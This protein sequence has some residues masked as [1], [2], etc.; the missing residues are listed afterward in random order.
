MVTALRNAAAPALRGWID[1]H[2]IEILYATAPANVGFMDPKLVDV[3]D[4]LRKRV[5]AEP[6]T[7]ALKQIGEMLGVTVTPHTQRLSVAHS[8]RETFTLGLDEYNE[9]KR[10]F[11]LYATDAKEHTGPA[12]PYVVGSVEGVSVNVP[13]VLVTLPG[14]TP[15][16]F[17]LQDS[18]WRTGQTFSS[19]YFLDKVVRDFTPKA[20]VSAIYPAL[21]TDEGRALLSA[22]IHK[23]T[24]AEEKARAA[25]VARAALLRDTKRGSCSVCF[26]AIALDPLIVPHGWKMKGGWGHGHVGMYR[27]GRGCSGANY[28]AWESSPA[29]AAAHAADLRKYAQTVE[30]E[31]L[32]RDATQIYD[33][34]A[35]V[36]LPSKRRV[37][38][39]EIGD[40]PPDATVEQVASTDKEWPAWNARLAAHL[41]RLAT[42]ANAEAGRYEEIVRRW[43][44]PATDAFQIVFGA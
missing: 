3:I 23:V 36:T 9:A 2:A 37:L 10:K 25:R 19:L 5:G 40:R 11:D 8:G 12:G 39:R 27:T 18:N 24:P 28:P 13:G 6:S 38:A 16:F 41:H 20:L 33:T 32:R 44:I 31:G 35:V 43:P 30:A 17:Y 7:K 34:I 22:L 1:A 29:G 26:E 15:M 14:S 42:I 21:F 4:R